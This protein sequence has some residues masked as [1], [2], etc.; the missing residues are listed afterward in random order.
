MEVHGSQVAS[1]TWVKKKG[2]SKVTMIFMDL[3]QKRILLKS[4]LYHIL[5]I[6]AGFLKRKSICMNTRLAASLLPNSRPPLPPSFPVSLPASHYHLIPDQSKQIS[7]FSS[8]YYRRMCRL[9]RFPTFL[10][11]TIGACVVLGFPLP[12]C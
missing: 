5:G 2:G 8:T 1:E 11:R 7:Y 9:S 3:Y 12:R 10:R 6:P 4:V